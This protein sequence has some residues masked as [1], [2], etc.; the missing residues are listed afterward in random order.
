M[1]INVSFNGST[2]YRPGAYTK[3]EIDL[4]GG[5]PLG[6]AGI[7]AII[8]ESSQGR[9]ASEEPDIRNNVFTPDQLTA[10]R[11]KYGSG[12]I[13]D[14][15]AWAFSPATDAAIPSG[16]Q[17]LYIIKTNQSVQAS[18]VLANSYGTVK[19][20]VYGTAGNR[21]TYGNVLTSETPA[22]ASSSTT[23]VETTLLT[24]DHLSVAVNGGAL[25]T[26]T[27]AHTVVDNADLVS[28]L[29]NAANWS[30]GLPVGVSIV[31]SGADGASRV[32]ITQASLSSA[33]QLGYGRS[34][35]IEGSAVAKMHL[36]AGLAVP[37]AEPTA[38]ITLQNL[39]TSA[40]EEDTLGGIVVMMVGNDDGTSASVVVDDAKINF[41]AVGGSNAGIHEFAKTSYQ[42]LTEVVQAINL[43]PGWSAQLSNPL[44]NQMSSDVLDQV[45]VSAFSASGAQPARL[46]KDAQDVKDFFAS[47]SIAALSALSSTGLPA[48]A[49]QASL[50]SGALGATASSDI[51]D[52]LD[53][54]TKVR[55]NTIAPL[56]SR[57]AADDVSDGLTDPT[58]SYTIAGIQQSVKT[59]LSAMAATKK[60]S[61]RQ[62]FIGLKDTFVNCKLAAATLAYFRIQL[63]I[64]DV[65]QTDSLGNIK[66]FQPYAL[67]ALCAGARSGC[68][69]GTP[70]T[71]K[72]LN[73]SGI[74]QTA[75][76]MIT[77]AADIVTDFDPDTQYDDAIANGVTFLESAQG[78]GYKVVVDNT[79]YNKDANWVY[80]RGS[81]V[82]A[83][84][85]IVYNLRVQ[86]EAIYVGVKNTVKATEVAS[87]IS[88][89]FS[90][91]LAQ[92]ITV[93]TSDAP[94]G[95]KSLSVQV[96][97]DTITYTVVAKLVEGI[98]FVL[99]DVILQRASSAA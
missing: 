49:I 82:Y 41:T 67:A 43:L 99:G 65:L 4:G 8:G 76:P 63:V 59:H 10:I 66:W 31:V 91:F 18:L 22:S 57:D 97:G 58:S 90:Q 79:T 12:P 6:P 29:A 3:T 61:E 81:C 74:R 11:N 77:P 68:P 75:Q 71:N 95:F 38:T 47:S 50:S 64:Q 72:Y 54:L 44:Y 83:A 52:G 27:P 37:A 53:L 35:E 30:A 16:A 55:V 15:A 56:F 5:F 73:L 51:T 26:W 7:V 2:I 60:R 33:Y 28:Q 24:S 86:L 94:G 39:S 62:A 14:A 92:G 34:F 85:I 80:N 32:A 23:F 13:V 45:S 40:S 20:L 42:T 19:S 88:S 69:V 98:D 78:G 1:A 84:D 17:A 9:P 48:A 96:S 93:S 36:S 89:I 21:N 25:N 70:L 87:V 46:K